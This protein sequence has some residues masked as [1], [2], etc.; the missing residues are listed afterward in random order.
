M[1]CC[2]GAPKKRVEKPKVQEKPKVK[3]SKEKKV[4]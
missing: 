1:S 2:L 4:K 3:I